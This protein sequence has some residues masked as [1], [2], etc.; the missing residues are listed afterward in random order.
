MLA[1]EQYCGTA[2]AAVEALLAAAEAAVAGG[3]PLDIRLMSQCREA[4]R[5]ARV[6]PFRPSRQLLWVHK[7]LLPP[8]PGTAGEF[9]IRGV[10][11]CTVTL[12]RESDWDVTVGT[13]AGT[14]TVCVHRAHTFFSPSVWAALGP[15][16]LAVAQ[17]DTKTGRVSRK[18]LRQA[19]AAAVCLPPGG[20][21]A[22]RRLRVALQAAG[23]TGQVA[24]VWAAAHDLA[25]TGISM[26][27]P[28]LWHTPRHASV[29][30]AK[31]GCLRALWVVLAAGGSLRAV[32][33]AVVNR[34]DKR[35][36]LPS[37]AACVLLAGVA[38]QPVYVQDLFEHATPTTVFCGRRAAWEVQ[39]VMVG[40]PTAACF[41]VWPE[42][43]QE[44]FASDRVAR[45]AW[46]AAGS[47]Y[48]GSCTNA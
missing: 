4:L 22:H 7:K 32:L 1:S 33:R 48:L 40:S 19:H 47:P 16:I 34:W 3:P 23:V 18:Q 37:V 42:C 39:S 46:A 13:P 2:G 28:D 41:Q 26:G 20:P 14:C 10:L 38:L 9:V 21:A 44:W 8:V 17:S 15:Y 35:G 6:L 5:L 45:D 12:R 11:L 30:A 31:S 25:A 24:P 27:T 36:G 29:A 43:C